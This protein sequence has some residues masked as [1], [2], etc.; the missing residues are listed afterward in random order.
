LGFLIY[1]L[2]LIPYSCRRRRHRRRRRRR[3]IVI[4]SALIN[5]QI[6]SGSEF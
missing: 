1:L 6:A 5:V 3:K 4:A 2:M